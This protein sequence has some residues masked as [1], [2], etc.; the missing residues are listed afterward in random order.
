MTGTSAPPGTWRVLGPALCVWGA[1]A[2]LVVAPGSA[3]WLLVAAGTVGLG[4]GV[5]AL[6]IGGRWAV[7]FRLVALAC[8]LLTLVGAR[9]TV[10]EHSRA[11][12]GWE[13]AAESWQP[14][15]RPV[16]LAGFPQRVSSEFEERSW[17]AAEALEPGGRLPV[18]LFLDGAPQPEWGPGTRLQVT[19]VPQQTSPGERQAF[20]VRVTEFSVASDPGPH[21]A[22]WEHL[23]ARLAGLAAELRHGLRAASAQVPGAAL[24]PGFAVGDTDLM[25]P[26]LDR[27]ML[28]SSLAHLTAVSGAN[29]AL[30]TGAVM[31]C[32][33]RCG[34]GRRLRIAAAAGGLL[35]FLVIVGPD[36]SVQRAAVMASVLL[37]TNFGG[38][39]GAALPALGTAI[40]TLLVIDPWQA[41]QAG[42]ALSVAATAGILLLAGTFEHW[43]RHRARVPRVLALPVSVALAAQLSCGPLLLL[44]EPGIPA[45]GVLANVLAAPAAPLGT[46]LGLA[47]A[48]LLPLHDGTGQLLVQAASLPAR[49][50]A[51][52]A[53]VT[54]GLPLARWYW[55]EGWAGA[56]LLAACQAGLWASWAIHRGHLTLPVVGRVP[57]RA[58]WQ[59]PRPV[60]ASVRRVVAVLVSASIGVF[61]AVSAVTPLGERLGT[62]AEWALVACDVGQGDAILVRDPTAAD[63]VMLIDTGDDPARLEACLERF[64]VDRVALL[65]LSHDDR[66]HVGALAAVVDRVDAAMI[67]PP[68]V[69]Q[70]GSDRE[71]VRELA[72][73]QVPTTVGGAGLSGA[74]TPSGDPRSTAGLRWQVLGPASDRAPH[75]TNAAS[76][77]LRVD[78]G[79]TSVLLL[80]DTGL[81]EQQPLVDTLGGI[82]VDVLKVS[83]HGS[84]NQDPRLPAATRAAWALISVGAGNGYGHPAADTLGALARAGARTLRTDQHGSIALIPGAGG[85]LEV[86]TERVPGRDVSARPYT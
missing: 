5:L 2:L 3:V 50:V 58:P 86:W 60:P 34:I 39:R 19:G 37:A 15:T 77:V 33:A 48:L 31:W 47:A 70:L 11:N 35:A 75:D 74:I 46:G 53:E 42:F 85:E 45:V 43:L 51:A 26:E 9:V 59:P 49:W 79:E 21:A 72:E 65:V 82:E 17:V 18:L 68:T 38:K 78:A 12:P 57:R 30:V 67:A 71:V 41:L 36:A 1:T 27:V 8:A 64:G 83:H 7:V 56:A 84:R 25:P 13:A 54:A 52:T 62:P 24:V 20:A 28:A 14:L 66:D 16:V 32:A 80:G 73:A 55:P 76:L 69:E 44:L 81:H 6:G 22:V 10:E 40:L 61:V 63:E 29:C 23:P 4:L